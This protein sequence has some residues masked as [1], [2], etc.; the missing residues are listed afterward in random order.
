MGAQGLPSHG[1]PAMSPLVIVRGGGDLATGVVW[2]LTRVGARVLVT[3][4]AEPLTVRRTVAL[5]TAVTDGVIDVEGMVGRPIDTLAGAASVLDAGEV[6]VVVSPA[7]PAAADVATHL[8]A[9]PDA[10]VDARLAKRNIDT[11]IDDAPLV[12]AL[13]P[14]FTVGVDCHAIVETMRGHHLGRVLWSGSAEPNTGTPG[15]VG[16]RDVDRVVRA[17]FSGVVR[18]NARIG[19]VVAEGDLLGTVAEGDRD[20]GA[21]DRGDVDGASESPAKAAEIRALFDGVVRG[22]ILDGA[23]VPAGAKIGD[24][25][26]RVDTPCDEIS[27]KALAIGGGVV[28]AVGA[29]WCP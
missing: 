11:T 8:G 29:L 17:P 28:E 5:S 12:V 27:D 4:L 18:W 26:P 9:A 23:A 1:S 25:D 22:L 7:L 16:G 3:E 15:L 13:G 20:A 6:P 2:R 14:G 24:V 19:D 10:V 21:D